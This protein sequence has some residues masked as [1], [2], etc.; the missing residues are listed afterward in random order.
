MLAHVHVHSGGAS[1]IKLAHVS[2]SQQ[3]DVSS[4]STTVSLPEAQQV[5]A[6][7]SDSINCNENIVENIFISIDTVQTQCSLPR[8]LRCSVCS[9]YS[10]I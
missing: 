10:C 3:T 5:L 9:H 6:R 4:W 2:T 1:E 7:R 8:I